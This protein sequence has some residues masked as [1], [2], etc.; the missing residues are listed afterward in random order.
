[1][2]NNDILTRPEWQDTPTYHNSGNSMAN[3]LRL[4]AQCLESL[5]NDP[6]RDVWLSV[7]LQVTREDDP[8]R[9]KATVDALAAALGLTPEDPEIGQQYRTGHHSGVS[10]YTAALAAQCCAHCAHSHGGVS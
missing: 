9:R 4:I 10:V 7:G 6:L 2:S 1:M 3:K 5:G 8:D